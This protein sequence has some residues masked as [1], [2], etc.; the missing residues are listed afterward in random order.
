MSKAGLPYSVLA[1]MAVVAGDDDKVNR[2]VQ[3]CLKDVSNRLVNEVVYK[4]D[5][6]DLPLVLAAIRAS[7]SGLESLLS[8]ED[9]L[10]EKIIVEE[11]QSIVI[12][13]SAL[14]QQAKGGDCNGSN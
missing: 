12:D 13:M 2:I 11:T 10:M 4:Y 5:H 6:L 3:E 8:E 7:T 9:R 1:G 14:R